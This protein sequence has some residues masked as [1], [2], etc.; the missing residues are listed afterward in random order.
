MWSEK[1]S[2][3]GI[4]SLEEFIVYIPNDPAVLLVGIYSRKVSYIVMKIQV[5]MALLIIVTI[6]KH[7]KYPSNARECSAYHRR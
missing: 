7:L 2:Y 1:D 5:C 3:I 4:Y 6:W